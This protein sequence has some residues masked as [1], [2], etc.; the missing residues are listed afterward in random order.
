MDNSILK[1]KINQAVE[2]LK[3]KNIDFILKVF[4]Q[5]CK[6][7]NKSHLVIVGKGPE[8]D[9]LLSLAKKLGVLERVHF[10]G[11]IEYEFMPLVY[12]DAEVFVFA[13]YT[14]TQGMCIL[15]ASASGIPIV[16][17]NDSAF[18]GMVEDKKSGYFLPLNIEKFAQELNYLLQNDNIRTKMG[19][20]AVKIASRNFDSGK[21]TKNLVN[22]Y[23]NARKS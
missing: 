3:E 15:E 11:A 4:K 1:E 14:E 13:S 2:I 8:S 9:N 20:E 23:L 22:I 21:I 6:T 12:K 16:A 5:L 10:T 19:E 18:E 7:D 17:N